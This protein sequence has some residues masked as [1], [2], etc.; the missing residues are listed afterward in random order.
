MSHKPTRASGLVRRLVRNVH[1]PQQQ[2]AGRRANAAPSRTR[3]KAMQNPRLREQSKVALRLLQGCSDS[4]ANVG[5]RM[6]EEPHEPEQ[7]H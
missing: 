3:G 6:A 1:T 7:A 4:S 5:D 2:T